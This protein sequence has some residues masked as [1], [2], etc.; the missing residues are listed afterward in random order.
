LR[1]PPRNLA[2]ADLVPARADSL[3][4]YRPTHP[5]RERRAA[6]PR[7]RTSAAHW[8]WLPVERW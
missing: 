6:G 2:P 8:S 5:C 3:L 7:Q 1:E 4:F